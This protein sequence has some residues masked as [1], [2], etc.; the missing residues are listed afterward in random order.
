MVTEVCG[1][2][3]VPGSNSGPHVHHPFEFSPRLLDE[4]KILSP[5]IITYFGVRTQFVPS[6]NLMIKVTNSLTSELLNYNS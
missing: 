3:Q 1:G 5:V 6:S 4:L 2:Q